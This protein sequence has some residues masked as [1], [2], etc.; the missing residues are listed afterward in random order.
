MDKE[1][2]IITISLTN[3]GDSQKNTITDN[4][5]LKIA[6]T[7]A[8]LVAKLGAICNDIETTFESA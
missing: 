7:R 4:R 2:F 8:E 1:I 3:P 6:G 5:F